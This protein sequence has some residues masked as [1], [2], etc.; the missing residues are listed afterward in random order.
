VGGIDTFAGAVL[1]V[2]SAYMEIQIENA[3]DVR[4]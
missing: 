1:D 2:E 3:D 4:Y